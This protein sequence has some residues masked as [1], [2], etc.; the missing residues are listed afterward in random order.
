MTYKL[1][2][3][4][5]ATLSGSIHCGAMCG[6]LSLSVGPNRRLQSIYQGA[7]LLAYLGLGA[8]AGFGGAALFDRDMLAWITAGGAMILAFYLV[9]SGVHL[10]FRGRPMEFVPAFLTP[11]LVRITRR[12][13]AF[14]PASRAFLTG[15]LTPFLPCAWLLTSV[16]LAVN[17]G[18]AGMGALILFSV[19]LGSL[20]AL[21]AGPSFFRFLTRKFQ[22]RGRK[23][24]AALM[25][26]AGLFSVMERVNH[27]AMHDPR[28]EP[29][30]GAIPACLPAWGIPEQH[31]SRSSMPAD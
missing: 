10:F 15:I 24:I 28:I 1:L 9:L 6:G 13:N 3:L 2:A 27:G 19:W 12:T 20:P 22:E 30:S 26:L 31:A 29:D 21:I 25:I 11:I 16:I 17:S 8:I 7:R 14:H 18:N 5:I 4:L 23:A